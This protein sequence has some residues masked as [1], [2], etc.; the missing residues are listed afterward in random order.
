MK[1][2]FTL[3]QRISMF[4]TRLHIAIIGLVAFNRPL[5]I[6]CE[7]EAPVKIKADTSKPIYIAN[8]VITGSDTSGIRITE[9][10][11]AK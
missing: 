5:I 4:L 2:G 1:N 11:I 9:T 8:N 7:F 6:G 3:K 10:I